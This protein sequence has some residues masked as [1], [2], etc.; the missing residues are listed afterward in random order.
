M[1]G[2]K[3][4]KVWSRR[5]SFLYRPYSVVART[6]REAEEKGAVLWGMAVGEVVVTLVR[7]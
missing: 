5:F 4:W 1:F 7:R 6:Q 2:Q 3:K